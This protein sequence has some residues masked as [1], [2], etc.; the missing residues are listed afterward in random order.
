MIVDF[1][2]KN[3]RSVRSTV[4]L[5]FEAS[6][7]DTHVKENV[8]TMPDGV[9]L[10]KAATIFGNN[11][12]GKTNLT[13]AF[14]C[15]Y[16]MMTTLPQFAVS[17]LEYKP[18]AFDQPCLGM[19]TSMSMTFYMNGIRH[20]MKLGFAGDMIMEEMLSG[21]FTARPSTI[22]HRKINRSGKQTVS[23]GPKAGLSKQEQ[24]FVWERT[25]PNRTVMAT[26]GN[27]AVEKCWLTDVY[28]YFLS[29]FHG[30]YTSVSSM[31]GY[32]KEILANDGDGRI[33]EFLHEMLKAAE[34]ERE[35]E[36]VTGAKGSELRFWQ[37]RNGMRNVLSEDEESKGIMRFLGLSALLYKQGST[38]SFVIIDG[39]DKELH[40]LLRAYF[41]QRFLKYSLN[42]SQ[43]LFTTH[44]FYLLDRDYIR[45]DIIWFSEL[46]K[47][48]ATKLRRLSDMGGRRKRNIY[49]QYKEGKL[50]A[51]PDLT[52][53]EPDVERL[54]LFNLEEGSY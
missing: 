51:H 36:L 32:T 45:H 7:D 48:G 52:K 37:E 54:G 8:R 6:K 24:V 28:S 44:S 16:R 15:F 23:F 41:F 43:L 34:F 9:Q 20:I 35:V 39:L 19:A 2:V 1:K 47:H 14:V 42:T 5:S 25:T 18:F 29:G 40:P 4:T 26:L 3:F 13:K 31:M 33:K 50:S 30:V 53:Y 21:Y 22:Y 38:D 46:D 12:T 17:G 10:L 49:R 27:S 11:A